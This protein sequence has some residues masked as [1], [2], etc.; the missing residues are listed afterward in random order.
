[1]TVFT[2]FYE[3][4]AQELER[5]HKEWVSSNKKMRSI[6]LALRQIKT[7]GDTEITPAEEVLRKEYEKEKAKN[8][9]ICTDMYALKGFVRSMEIEANRHGV[10]WDRTTEIFGY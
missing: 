1:M 3:E 2:T 6:E 8:D 7:E 9:K 10:T 4:K 5:N